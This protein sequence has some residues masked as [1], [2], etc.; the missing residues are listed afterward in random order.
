[1]IR[2]DEFEDFVDSYGNGLTIGTAGTIGGDKPLPKGWMPPPREFPI[3]FHVAAPGPSWPETLP[4][5]P[6]KRA[7]RKARAKPAKAPAARKAAKA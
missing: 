7:P 2:A 4:E 3:G 5:A 6:P 1:M